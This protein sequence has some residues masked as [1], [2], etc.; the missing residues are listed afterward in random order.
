MTFS[1][2]SDPGANVNNG[3]F[4]NSGKVKT[5]EAYQRALH[6]T[7][8]STKFACNISKRKKILTL[9]RCSLSGWI[10]MNEINTTLAPFHFKNTSVTPL[11][12]RSSYFGRNAIEWWSLNRTIT[13]E[14]ASAW[15]KRKRK[16]N[17][18]IWPRSLTWCAAD[19]TAL[20][21][22]RGSAI[23]EGTFAYS[24]V[25]E[26]LLPKNQDEDEHFSP[27]A[28]QPNYEVGTTF[29]RE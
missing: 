20:L 13:S 23:W 10:W 5:G 25:Q 14:W 19:Q 4:S 21:Q 27:S 16:E 12:H 24:L 8:S 29:V 1:R 3:S 28:G 2:S 15:P 22:E 11:K 6:S 9:M 26:L 17:Y 18:W 7:K